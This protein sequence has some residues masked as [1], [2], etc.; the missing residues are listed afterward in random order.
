MS[1]GVISGNDKIIG[2]IRLK[3]RAE[4]LNDND[5]IYK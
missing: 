1:K 2:Y 3:Y 5:S 4:T